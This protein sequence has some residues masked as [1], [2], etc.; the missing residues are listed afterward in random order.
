MYVVFCRFSSWIFFSLL[1]SEHSLYILNTS[2]LLDTWFANIFS[3][4]GIGKF[5][6]LHKEVSQN[7]LILMKFGL[8]ILPF[9]NHAFSV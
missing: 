9:M 6:P 4:T 1:I 5:H 8:P 3:Q 2:A 7:T